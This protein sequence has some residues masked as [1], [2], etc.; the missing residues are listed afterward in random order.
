MKRYLH[1]FIKK[2]LEK[3]MVFMGGPRQVGKTTISKDLLKELDS[4]QYYNWDNSDHRKIIINKNWDSAKQLIVLDEIHKYKPWKSFIKG[5]Y[6]TEEKFKALITGSAKL[7]VYRKGGDS[8]LGR[9]YY[10]RLH[11]L[12]LKE[13]LQ[14]STTEKKTN[15]NEILKKLEKLGPFPEPYLD[16]DSTNA[17]RWR[18]E[19][20]ER[21]LYEDILAIE[22]VRRLSSLELLIDLLRERVASPISYQSLSEDIGVSPITIKSWIDLLERMYLIFIVPP[23]NR[24]LKRAIK[25]E[26][27]VYFYDFS[28]IDSGGK[29]FENLI[30][31][32][33]IKEV[34]FLEDTQGLKYKLHLLRD[35]EKREVDFLIAL[36]NKP[37]LLIEVKL[38]DNKADKSLLYYKNKLTNIKAI[39]VV[40]NLNMSNESKGIKILPAVQFLQESL[41]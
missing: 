15:P 29:Q 10:Y 32:H 22:E 39:Q 33:L 30:A 5:I 26:S 14:F 17:N 25:K 12:S 41:R 19:R 9:Y 24:S 37:V 2:D 20:L 11:P 40:R 16:N 27:K 13:I 31:A 21:I 18:K 38:S 4:D 8:L 28:D 3:K 1:P 23:Y 7:N 35:K 36:N 34:N 6:D